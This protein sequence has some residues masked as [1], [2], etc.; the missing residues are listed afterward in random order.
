VRSLLGAAI[1]DEADVTVVDMEAGLEHLSR[2]GGTLAYSDVLL[3]VMEPS[4]KSVVT[5][6][7]TL[8]LAEELGIPRICAVGN[9]AVLP[10]DAEFYRAAAAEEGLL[11]AGIV[12]HDDDI[13]AADREGSIL[14][15]DRAGAA[16]RAV[17]EVVAVL[18]S[19]EAERDALLR[20]R[21][22]VDR[23]LA[24]IEKGQTGKPATPS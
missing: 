24:E 11:L 7:R 20:A 2:S 17:E 9:K 14:S 4:R 6:A 10:G 16:R 8:V 19:P 23:R 21:Q 15:P 5:A 22:R 18:E 3:V 12:P 1:E 13:V